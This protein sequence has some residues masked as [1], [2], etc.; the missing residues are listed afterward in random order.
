M[1]V[2]D[3]KRGSQVASESTRSYY[4]KEITIKSLVNIANGRGEVNGIANESVRARAVDIAK[5]YLADKSVNTFN[6]NRTGISAR[7]W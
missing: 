6:V 3:I 5:S 1:N 2:K 4:D 7:K